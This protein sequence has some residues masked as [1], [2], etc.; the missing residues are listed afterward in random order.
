M[1]SVRHFAS[2]LTLKGKVMPSNKEFIYSKFNL[3]WFCLDLMDDGMPLDWK[4]REERKD[5]QIK[6]KLSK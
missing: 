6:Q 5:L 2:K 3:R 1:P 4:K